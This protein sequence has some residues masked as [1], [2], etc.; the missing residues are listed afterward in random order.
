MTIFAESIIRNGLGGSADVIY[1]NLG[2]VMS[3]EEVMVLRDLDID[4]KY[5]YLRQKVQLCTSNPAMLD[6]ISIQIKRDDVLEESFRDLNGILKGHRKYC[7]L[8][9]R[10][11]GENGLD[12][13]GLTREFFSIISSKL[14]DPEKNLFKSQHEDNGPFQPNGWSH[15]LPDCDE[16]YRFIGRLVGKAITDNENLDS[17]VFTTP[18]LKHMIGTYL[19]P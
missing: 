15:E 9:V 6:R 4:T 18:F 17:L 1:R 2:E 16:Y 8:N 11:E 7:P 13:G 10:F 14:V 12:G 3:E 5:S 19:L